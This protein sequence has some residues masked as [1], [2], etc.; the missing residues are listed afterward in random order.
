MLMVSSVTLSL[1]DWHHAIY[2]KSCRPSCPVVLSAGDEQFSECQVSNNTVPGVPSLPVWYA[3]CPSI[4]SQPYTVLCHRQ[5]AP[6]SGGIVV[7]RGQYIT[8]AS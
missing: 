6:H 3:P 4:S 7:M 2:Y 5:E 8:H 1:A